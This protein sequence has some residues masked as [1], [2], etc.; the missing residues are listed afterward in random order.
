MLP[1]PEGSIVFDGSM[2]PREFV[3]RINEHDAGLPAPELARVLSKN[4][5]WGIPALTL[6][7][8]ATSSEVRDQRGISA[9]RRAELLREIRLFHE[10]ALWQLE[11]RGSPLDPFTGPLLG[12]AFSC[13]GMVEELSSPITL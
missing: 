5:Y 11:D 10:T 4:P 13:W 3:R 6:R 12:I 7:L 2:S 1:S 8:E 9:E